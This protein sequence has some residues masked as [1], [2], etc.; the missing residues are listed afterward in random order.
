MTFKIH[1]TD[2]KYDTWTVEQFLKHELECVRELHET[3]PDPMWRTVIEYLER[4]LDG[5]ILSLIHI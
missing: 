3:A 2:E 5:R 4:R 1:M